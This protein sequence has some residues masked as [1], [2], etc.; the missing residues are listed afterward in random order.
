M[1]YHPFSASLF[2]GQK[3]KLACTFVAK[4]AVTLR[5]RQGDMG[6]VDEM[7]LTANPG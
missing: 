4:S 5:V 7:I 1:S 2:D 6:Q 3:E